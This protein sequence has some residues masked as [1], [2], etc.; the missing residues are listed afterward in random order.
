[1]SG[2]KAIFEDFQLVNDGKVCIIWTHLFVKLF[3]NIH[4]DF[5]QGPILFYE[6]IE[7]ITILYPTNQTSI[8]SQRNDR[9]SSD[10]KLSSKIFPLCC[11]KFI[12]KTEKLHNTLVKSQILSAFQQEIVLLS[13]TTQNSQ[14]SWT[15][16]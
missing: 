13:V 14:F 2:L 6:L 16:F 12:N 11:K 3:L 9:I 7:S 5:I 15:L 1:M 10:F 8:N 4:T